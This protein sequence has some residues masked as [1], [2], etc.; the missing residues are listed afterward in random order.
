PRGPLGPVRR[1]AARLSVTNTS[2]A[3]CAIVLLLLAEVDR[4]GD[5]RITRAI[6]SEPGRPRRAPNHPAT[7]S[8]L[9]HWA[10]L[11]AGH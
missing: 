5:G 9:R 10:A 11:S 6:A 1:Q 2:P 4:V 3:I 7:S 8:R